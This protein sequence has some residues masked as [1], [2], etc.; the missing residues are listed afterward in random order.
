M[1]TEEEVIEQAW[2][3]NPPWSLAASAWIFVGRVRSAAIPRWQAST[4]TWILRLYLVTSTWI[5][6]TQRVA[7]HL[8]VLRCA[9]NP[10]GHVQSAANPRFLDLDSTLGSWQPPPGSSSPC[11][12]C[13]TATPR[14]P[15]ILNDLQ[16]SS[17]SRPPPGHVHCAATPQGSTRLSK[18]SVTIKTRV[19][20]KILV[21]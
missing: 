11:H 15:A 17:T 16:R 5:L 8:A 19:V 10:R 4:W 9:A 21:P 1:I 20:E 2:T 18:I 7:L 12:V 3:W 6:V 13:S 14:C